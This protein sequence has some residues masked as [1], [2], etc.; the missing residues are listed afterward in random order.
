MT[1]LFLPP[2]LHEEWWDESEVEVEV[3]VGV[4]RASVREAAYTRSN[5]VRI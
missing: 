4:I 1:S 2:P 3:V 5:R